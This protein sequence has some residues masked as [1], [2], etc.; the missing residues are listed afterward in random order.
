MNVVT[1]T[2]SSGGRATVA[3]FSGG[4]SGASGWLINTAALA[5]PSGSKAIS[6]YG[7][8]CAEPTGYVIAN[9]DTVH[10]RCGNGTAG[11][12]L[13][14]GNSFPVFKK[15]GTTTLPVTF[16]F[17][18]GTI[19][20]ADAGDNA[21]L[22][23]RWYNN[24]NQW[25]SFGFTALPTSIT[26][27]GVILAAKRYANSSSNFKF[28]YAYD[29]NGV[30]SGYFGQYFV[31]CYVTYSNMDWEDARDTGTS[32]FK[33]MTQGY[34]Q[35]KSTLLDCDLTWR[36]SWGTDDIIEGQ[37]NQPNGVQLIGGSLSFYN[38]AAAPSGPFAYISSACYN[39]SVLLAGVEINGLVPGCILYNNT[40]AGYLRDIQLLDCGGV[41][42]FNLL[43]ASSIVRNAS[44]FYPRSK[45]SIAGIKGSGFALDTEKVNVT[46]LPGMGFPY[47]NGLVEE[48]QPAA[49]RAEVSVNGKFVSINDPAILFD[50]VVFNDADSAG[51]KT[52][53]MQVAV[54]EN[55][56]LTT[57]TL[58][59]HVDYQDH[60]TGKT[61]HVTTLVSPAE[62]AALT[63]STETWYPEDG[64]R[65]F[66]TEGTAKYYNK[67]KLT[68]TTPTTVKA[69]SMLRV[70]VSAHAPISATGRYI[71][72]DP[73]IQVA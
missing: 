49:L 38:L 54:D 34:E 23:L 11:T 58:A 27:G 33:L 6:A 45:L 4:F 16:V 32:N 40:D 46:W 68:L 72:V 28:Q 70:W 29:N 36:H 9:G 15:R 43:H 39:S 55:L 57:A 14:L 62:A 52:L 21:Q 8:L 71:F 47:L 19:W 48:N 53:T 37:A 24:T 69:N 17:D 2:T 60:A 44:S 5:W 51:A 25:A 66:Y 10:V 20:T 31:G 64:G 7:V 50:T 61:R 67:K 42:N 35:R 22:L 73:Y 56:A 1:I 41:Q 12:T 30:S 18:N 3:G 13:T 63:V 26:D 65:P 59:L